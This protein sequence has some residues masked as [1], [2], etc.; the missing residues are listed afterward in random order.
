M[1]YVGQIQPGSAY[2]MR[3]R[4]ASEPGV[5][6]HSSGAGSQSTDALA[7]ASPQTGSAPRAGRCSGS[8]SSGR[9]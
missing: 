1:R 5:G 2:P 8:R 7:A 3:C 6:R 9:C 4:R